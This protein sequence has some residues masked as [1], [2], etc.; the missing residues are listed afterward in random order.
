MTTRM[1]AALAATLIAAGAPAAAILAADG[2]K[3]AI[4]SFGV[5]LAQMDRSVKPGDDFFRYVNG[6]WL[7]TVA[8]PADKARYGMFDALRDKAEADVMALVESLAKTPQPA[9]SVRQKVG[10]LYA[11]FMDQARVEA[12]GL[13]PLKADLA[14]IAAAKTK[15]DV[16]RLMCRRDYSGPFAIGIS[17]DPADPSRYVVG[18]GQAGLGM[19]SR[20]YYLSTGPKFDG[21]R[22]AYRTYLTRLLELSG[23]PAP[24]ATA[25][26][27]IA[28]E[29]KLATVHW[30]PERRRN[31][32]ETNNPADRAGLATM[33]PAIDW[34][35]ALEAS[36]LGGAQRFVVRETSALRD[37]TALLDSEPVATWR[38]YL[39][40]HLLDSYADYLP[41]AFEEANFAFAGKALRGVE[42]QRERAKRG[43][44]LLDGLIGEGVGELYVAKH[45][46]PGHKAK[47]DALVANLRAA[48]GERLRTLAWMDDATRA[49]AL[50][51][52][53]TFDP[54]IGYPATWRD[55][56][57]F[58]VARDTLFENVR[59]GQL[60]E[61]RRRV[62]RL[63]G[64]VDR[65]EWRMNPQTVNASYSP[66]SNQIT[67]PAGIL[68]PPFFDPY[69]D[70][71]VNYGA[72]GAVI[73][74]E[75]G[76][77]FDD[78]GREFDETG[79]VRNWWSEETNR[80]FLA[81]TERL[82]A[83]YGAHCPLP[84]LCVNGKLT[85]G[86]NLGDL[87]GIEMAYAAYKLSLKG[88]PAPVIDGFTGDQRFFL[89]YAQV[90][91]SAMREDALRNLILTNPHSPG[92]ARASIPVRNVDAWYA[93]FD[94]KPGDKAYLPPDQRVHIW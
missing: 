57:D 30:A 44:T 21:Y 50:R 45:F 88:T 93:A 28:L 71:A 86:E 17:A 7:A 82:G 54:R 43:I 55:Y 64:P 76:H 52:L 32:K 3:P 9:G 36:G 26:A 35:A 81:A 67:F 46:P 72:I 78:Q 13:E 94:V 37:G 29:T 56:S 91:R 63:N 84:N 15:A 23:D 69:A 22:A 85:M 65:G 74:H 4:G 41:K 73:G 48:M 31:V 92:E 34:P 47:M 11:S 70:P 87:G 10:D 80:K 14:A 61:W 33:I 79:K 18:I 59:N 68:Q 58:P 62:A 66:L 24:A 53:A 83:Q 38:A 19:P 75:I 1:R 77:G 42:V 6:R 40:V 60:F 8:I 49:Q 2:G 27:V 89:A 90:W 20:D 12:R 51:K 25:D 5:D 16:V 39:V